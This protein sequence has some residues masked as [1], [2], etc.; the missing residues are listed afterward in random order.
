MTTHC[1]SNLNFYQAG[2]LFKKKLK[3]LIVLI[4]HLSRKSC[5]FFFLG[6]GDGIK[7]LTSILVQTLKE[8]FMLNFALNFLLFLY[9]FT[10][11]ARTQTLVEIYNNNYKNKNNPIF[12][13]NSR[14]PHFR[15][16]ILLTDK[17]GNTIA[18]TTTLIKVCNYVTFVLTVMFWVPNFLG[19][20]LRNSLTNFL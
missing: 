9:F 3:I 13:K 15:N 4:I 11:L 12:K 5:G 19:I 7:Q 16:M 20:S 10:F 8:K 18:V 1:L 6:G 17:K 14:W 2:R